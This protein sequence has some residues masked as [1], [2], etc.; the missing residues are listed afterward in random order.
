MR[1]FSYAM[2]QKEIS[3]GRLG[4]RRRCK[5]SIL[6]PQP[7][8]WARHRTVEQRTYGLIVVGVIVQVSWQ[9]FSEQ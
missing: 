4:I 8:E 3:Q 2:E 7:L 1:L 6:K 9:L 5:F